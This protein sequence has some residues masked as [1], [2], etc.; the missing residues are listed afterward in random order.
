MRILFVVGIS[1]TTM[2]RVSARFAINSWPWRH[3]VRH[4]PA[5]TVENSMPPMADKLL[6]SIKTDLNSYEQ[7]K[8]VMCMANSSMDKP[9][10][11]S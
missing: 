11:K 9:P 8:S 4:G 6:W 5:V 1:A 10:A 7:P 3:D 2:C